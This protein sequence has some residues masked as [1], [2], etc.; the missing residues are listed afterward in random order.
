MAPR[1]W[2]LYFKSGW[3][4]RVEHQAALLVRGRRRVAVAVLTRGSPSPA[5]ARA[6]EEG[7]FSRLLR[8]L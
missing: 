1:G 8:R 6:T 3:T 7:V 5:Y 2:T 4:R